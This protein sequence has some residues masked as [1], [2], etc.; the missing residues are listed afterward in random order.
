MA[1]IL[2]KDIAKEAGVSVTTVSFVVNGRAK[3][4][5]ISDDIIQKVERLVEVRNFKPNVFAKGLRTGK[6]TTIALIVEDIGNFFFGN[7]AK[8]IELAAYKKG[9]KVLFASTDNDDKKANELLSIMK[10]Q[11]VDG[12]IIIPTPGMKPAIQQLIQK[13][14]PVVLF[15]RY[16]PDVDTNYVVLDNFKGAYDLTKAIIEKG[17]KKIGFVTI[18]SQMTQMAERKAGYLKCLADHG[19]AMDKKRIIEFVFSPDIS[20][21]MAAM[22]DYFKSTDLDAVFFATNYLGIAGLECLQKLNIAI[23][24]Q[25]GVASFDDHDLFRLY[26]PPVSVV[27]QP[28]EDLANKAIDLLLLLMT[29]PPP[30]APRHNRVPAELIVRG[31]L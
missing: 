16:F 14:V 19:T 31:S 13:G 11:R 6:T 20:F 5:R 8:T 18:E 9:Y 2:L 21:E 25:M 22:E 29:S 28:V 24:D 27:A 10:N 23:P 12:L 4:K 7:V 26:K 3:E 17:Y 30:H 15:D 1:N